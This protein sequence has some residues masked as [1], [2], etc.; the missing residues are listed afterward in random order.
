MATPDSPLDTSSYM[1]SGAT[2]NVTHDLGNLNIGAEYHG[3]NN[4]HMDNGA[5]LSL[6]HVGCSYFPTISST[7]SKTLLS[8]NLLHVPNITKNLISV[9]QFSKDNFIYFEFHLLS[10]LLRTMPRGQFYCKGVLGTVS[11]NSVFPIQNLSPP[12]ASSLC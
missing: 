2:N 4:L 10:V 6:S 1:D 12:Q 11:I 3:S 9:S 7:Q 8:K 5:G